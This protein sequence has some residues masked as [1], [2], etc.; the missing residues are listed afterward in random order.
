[1]WS[2]LKTVRHCTL[3]V[4]ARWALEPRS[5]AFT[6][7]HVYLFGDSFSL[8]FCFPLFEIR[9]PCCVRVAYPQVRA[10]SGYWRSEPSSEVLSWVPSAG[11]LPLVVCPLETE[12]LDSP[13]FEDMG[14]PTAIGS[15]HA[16]TL[17]FLS[18]SV[19]LFLR[20]YNFAA[21]ARGLSAGL[22]AVGRL[23]P[24]A[25]LLRGAQ[26][27]AERGSFASCRLPARDRAT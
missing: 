6:L 8:F 9:E 22:R 5:T 1:M 11:P 24:V 20:Y 7:T 21:R 13:H 12:P 16:R 18:F 10:L 27:G 19:S 14:A 17:I 4:W 3:L 23:A 2:P 15:V 26:L 25:D